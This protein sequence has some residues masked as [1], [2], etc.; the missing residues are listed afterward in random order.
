MGDNAMRGLDMNRRGLWADLHNFAQ[1]WST[2]KLQIRDQADGGFRP[3]IPAPEI[4]H[5]SELQ[6]PPAGET[7][8]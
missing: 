6:N 2:N 1:R 3:L 8:P 7:L 5:R 4:I